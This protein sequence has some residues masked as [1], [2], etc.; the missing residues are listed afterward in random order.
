MVSSKPYN[1]KVVNLRFDGGREIKE[2]VA[3]NNGDNILQEHK[4][5]SN[6]NSEARGHEIRKRSPL[7][8]WAPLVYGV[9]ALG[10]KTGNKIG[11]KISVKLFG[12]LGKALLP[13]VLP[14]VG[15]LNL[16]VTCPKLSLAG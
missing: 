5:A 9:C 10:T 4:V 6:G 3:S 15:K 7:P 14:T 8:P 16:A 13:V 1:S 12:P 2:V 11:S